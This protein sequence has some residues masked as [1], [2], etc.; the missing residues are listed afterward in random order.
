MTISADLAFV[1]EGWSWIADAQPLV[2]KD[3]DLDPIELKQLLCAAYFSPSDDAS[4]DSYETQ[5]T[6]FEDDAIHIALKLLATEEEAKK[7]TIAEAVWREILWVV[8]R[9]REVSITVSQGK[10]SVEFGPENPAQAGAAA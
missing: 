7:H 3:S 10:V 1:G 2:T 8:P 6:R 4:A 5:R 9:D